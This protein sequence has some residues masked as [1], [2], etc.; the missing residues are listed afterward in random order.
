M[1]IHPTFARL[2]LTS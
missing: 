1:R 2:E